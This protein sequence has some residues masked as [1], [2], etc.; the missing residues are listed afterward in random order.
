MHLKNDGLTVGELTITI[1]T[2]IIIGFIWANITK[3]KE[4]EKVYLVSDTQEDI[5]SHCKENDLEVL[6]LPEYVEPAMVAHH[7]IW[8]GKEKR[9]AILEISRPYKY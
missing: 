7:F 2:L 6:S 5:D 3:D 4:N 8:V 1:A 9:P